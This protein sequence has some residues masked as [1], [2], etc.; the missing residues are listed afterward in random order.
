MNGTGKYLTEKSVLL[1][2]HYN[3]KMD[4]ILDLGNSLKAAE[5]AIWHPDSSFPLKV[6]LEQICLRSLSLLSNMILLAGH[7]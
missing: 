7:K 6:I 3:A 2:Q 5:D 1:E 4:G